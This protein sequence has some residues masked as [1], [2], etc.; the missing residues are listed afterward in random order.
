MAGVR[1]STQS[2]NFQS[3]AEEGQSH[4]MPL[5]LT[6]YATMSV[7]SSVF[8][9]QKTTFLQQTRQS[10]QN[11]DCKGFEDSSQTHKSKSSMKSQQRRTEFNEETLREHPGQDSSLK[12]YSDQFNF[13]LMSS[14]KHSSSINDDS[15]FIDQEAAE[16]SYKA[17][18]NRDQHYPVIKPQRYGD[19]MIQQFP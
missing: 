7:E 14:Q 4:S 16:E 13:L 3:V 8:L 17:E 1:Q 18:V 2:P 15:S 10:K 9:K 19:I 6:T 5:N 12:D 11:W